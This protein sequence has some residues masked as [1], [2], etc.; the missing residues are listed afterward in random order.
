MGVKCFIKMVGE[1]VFL[2]K[3]DFKHARV[4]IDMSGY[5]YSSIHALGGN[6]LTDSDGEPTAALQQLISL[7]TALVK[8]GAESVVV[9]LDNPKLNPMKMK[10]YGERRVAKAKARAKA[11]ECKDVTEKNK[12]EV[13]AK[14]VSGVVMNYVQ[15][16][17]MLLGMEVHV[18]APGREAEQHCADLAKDG[19]ID[20]VISNDTDAVMFGAARVVMVNKSVGGRKYKMVEIRH[21][22]VLTTL[23]VDAPMLVRMC[24]ALGTDFAPKTEGIGAKRVKTSGRNVELTD[25]QKIAYEYI[26]SEPSDEPEII[27]SALDLNAAVKWLVEKRGF[28]HERADKLVRKTQ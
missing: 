4:A 27:E 14:S 10:A 26:M 8:R 23:D 11:A 24:I 15:H 17:S 28:D 6:Q 7:K 3:P 5:I 13:R 9:V 19:A 16:L 18:V 25:E 20:I 1:D 22:D 21:K 2:L 12:Y